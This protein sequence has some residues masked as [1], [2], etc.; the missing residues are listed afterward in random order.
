MIFERFDRCELFAATLARLFNDR[1]LFMGFYM[2]QIL[3]IP[4]H[5]IAARLAHMRILLWVVLTIV[6]NT[7]LNGCAIIFTAIKTIARM[8]FIMY[9]QRFS[10][11]ITVGIEMKRETKWGTTERN[12]NQQ[13]NAHV[14]IGNDIGIE[15][16]R[17]A[18]IIINN[19]NKHLHFGTLKTC[20]E[21]GFSHRFW[22][23][24]NQITFVARFQ[25][26]HLIHR[27]HTHARLVGGR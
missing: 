17:P 3:L 12:D 4:W 15:P 8:K 2:R 25:R 11:V 7:I 5:W 21:F 14:Y 1:F 19:N 24:F 23:D 27:F 26:I 20:V 10:F 13:S 22:F 18:I 16:T 9:G 6:D